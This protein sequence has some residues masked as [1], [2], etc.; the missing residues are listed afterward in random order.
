MIITLLLNSFFML[1]LLRTSWREH[2]LFRGLLRVVY[3]SY[4]H[5]KIKSYL[6][7]F[8]FSIQ[9][10]W[11]QSYLPVLVL[12]SIECPGSIS[13]NKESI[14][15][16]NSTNLLHNRLGHPSKHI[17]QIILK[18]SCMISGYNNCNACQQQKLHKLY[19][20]TFEI[21]TKQ[22]LELIHPDLWGLPQ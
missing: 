18:K 22:P 12:V 7:M 13:F 2:Y 14:K 6:P 5:V 16:V 21:K 9:V 11:C 17:I 19:F 3:I 20:S 8:Q 10:L 4:C 1:V 15:I